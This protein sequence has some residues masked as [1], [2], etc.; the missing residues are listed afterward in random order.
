MSGRQFLQWPS[1]WWRAFRYHFVPPSFLP[2]AL[3]AVVAWAAA[4][5]FSVGAYVLVMLA[6]TLN[7]IALNMTDDYYDFIHSVDQAAGHG[8]N[9]Y[10]GGSG[11]LTSGAL[12]P[13][14]MRIAFFAL[15]LLTCAAGVYLTIV[16][17]WPV[18]VFG[19]VGILSAYFYTAPPIRYA[20]RGFGEV[21][22]LVNFSLILGLGS[23]FVQARSL[24]WEP[25]FAVLPLG[26]MMFSM[27]TINEIPDADDDGSGGKRTLVVLFGRRAAVR[28]YGAGLAAAYLVILIAPLVG[29]STFWAYGAFLTLPWG[30]KAFAVLRANY[31]NPAAMA[32][33]NMLTI[34]IHNMTG[35]LLIAA[36]VIR[37]ATLGR[38][39]IQMPI[40]LGLLV[41]LYLPVAMKIFLPPRGRGRPG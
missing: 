38:P 14:S 34:R 19:L 27:I 10:S 6:V 4:G 5:S 16:R 32:P 21:S 26:F 2:A 18:L 35:L 39:L 23:F 13:G 40:P 22:Q 8:K 3:G 25:V 28:L 17:G 1:L 12:S 24:S 11:V 31:E 33:A 15:Y 9:P 36:Y 41:V 7:H 20:Y 37:G 29:F 30:V